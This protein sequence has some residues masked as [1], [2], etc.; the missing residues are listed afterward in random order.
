[1]LIQHVSGN[2]TMMKK[3][4]GT[5]INMIL[6]YLLIFALQNIRWMHGYNAKVGVIN[7]NDRGS[8]VAFYAASNCG[9]LYNWTTNQMRILQGHVCVT[10]LLLL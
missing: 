7:L 8:T 3:V 5:S 6:F 10:N 9:V 4:L 1:M 2:D